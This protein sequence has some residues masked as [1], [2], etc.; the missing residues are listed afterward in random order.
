MDSIQKRARFA[1][2]LYLILTVSG[3]LGL[4]VW[5]ARLFVWGDAGA[6]AS[7]ILASETLYR[8]YI[9]NGIVSVTVF[10]FL[11]LALYRLLE[12]VDRAQAVLMV[13]LVLVQVP[14]A[15]VDAL[16]QTAALVLLHGADYLAV[17]DKVQRETLAMLFIDLNRL[18]TIVLEL[19]WGLWLFPLGALVYRSRFLPRV[20]GAW[21]ILTGVAYVALCFTGLLTP[22]YYELANKIAFPVLLGEVAFMLWLLVMGAKP[23]A[24]AAPGA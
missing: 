6:T 10:L 18:G 8:V 22:Q 11:A 14:M 19:F 21:L 15:Y 1:G 5:P 4:M 12:E 7:R 23:K 16:N 24:M 20:L 3:I 13:I 9:L 2:L 17:F